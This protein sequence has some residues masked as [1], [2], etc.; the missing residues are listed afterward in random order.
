MKT[1][2]VPFLGFFS[3]LA[4][5]EGGCTCAS[6][7]LRVEDAGGADATLQIEDAGGADAPRPTGAPCNREAGRPPTIQWVDESPIVLEA[8]E[9]PIELAGGGAEFGITYLHG[10]HCESFGGVGPCLVGATLPSLGTHTSI[11]EPF[12]WATDVLD[13]AWRGLPGPRPRRYDVRRGGQSRPGEVAWMLQTVGTPSAA[14]WQFQPSS[15]VPLADGQFRALEGRSIADVMPGGEERL[16]YE[17][18]VLVATHR[19]HPV[20]P[21][22]VLP[23]L[24]LRVHVLSADDGTERETHDIRTDLPFDEPRLVMARGGSRA[25]VTYVQDFDFPRAVQ[26]QALDTGVRRINPAGC[27]GAGFGRGP[28]RAYDVAA[29]SDEDILVVEEC[30]RG[31]APGSDPMTFLEWRTWDA[32]VASVVVR[33]RGD[34]DANSARS[35]VAI[36]RRGLAWIAY[37]AEGSTTMHV[38]AYRLVRPAPGAPG[39]PALEQVVASEVPVSYQTALGGPVAYLAI[40][41]SDDD[42]V[43]LGWSVSS[44]DPVVGVWPRA[45]VARLRL[46]E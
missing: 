26:L 7:V 25:W 12:S 31:D 22:S 2:R 44:L 32:G 42:T 9:S 24:D 1:H 36:D 23:Y 29:A 30:G 14:V 17:G 11:P 41:A 8:T 4:S 43:A 27:G 46:C 38:E 33:R 15:F 6:T 19:P 20:A 21:D 16:P 45:A 10:H 40:A 28:V 35:R 13:D 18:T 37:A 39:S 34:D 3:L 5:L